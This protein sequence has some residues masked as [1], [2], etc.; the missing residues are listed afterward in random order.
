MA[1]S[2]D[3]S[4]KSKVEIGRRI[5]DELKRIDDVITSRNRGIVSNYM[6]VEPFLGERW[7]DFKL[8]LIGVD[9][10]EQWLASFKTQSAYYPEIDCE[11]MAALVRAWKICDV[12]EKN[13]TASPEF[14]NNDPNDA[15]R[16]Y[17]AARQAVEKLDKQILQKV[18]VVNVSIDARNV[19]YP[20]ELR[21]ESFDLDEMSAPFTNQEFEALE[22][23]FEELKRLR[24][25]YP[26]VDCDAFDSLMK[27]RK[28]QQ[29]KMV[30]E[31]KRLREKFGKIKCV[32]NPQKNGNKKDDDTGEIVG[33]GCFMALVLI[34]IILIAI[35]SS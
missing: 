6:K 32:Q 21:F 33:C 12:D 28:I 29:A 35:A 30:A 10:V 24:S 14:A 7:S 1:T 15:A 17:E 16:D 19:T 3:F 5:L 2:N 34:S 18:G 8:E 23:W 13:P 9:S 31:T 20:E 27:E 25:L 4:G 22:A 26:K 11:R